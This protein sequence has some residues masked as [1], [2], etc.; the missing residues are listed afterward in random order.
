MNQS[1]HNDP[2]PTTDM[3]NRQKKLLFRAMRRGFKEADLILGSFAELNLKSMTSLELEAF[4]VLLD[5]PDHDLYDWILGR[6]VAPL[7]FQGQV[8][9]KIKLYHTEVYAKLGQA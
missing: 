8:L 5:Q 4:E 9:E 6:S 2:K 3:D 1:C 7:A